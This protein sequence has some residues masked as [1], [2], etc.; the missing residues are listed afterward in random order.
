MAWISCS[1]SLPK[2]GVPVLAVIRHRDRR[3]K[4]EAAV[5]EY[6]VEGRG[7]HDF[8]TGWYDVVNDD[9]SPVETVTHWQPIE[10]LP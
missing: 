8:D 2:V 9:I 1:E 3:R 5:L 7:G 4:P 10:A 6:W